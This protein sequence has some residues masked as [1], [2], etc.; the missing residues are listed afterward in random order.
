MTWGPKGDVSIITEP[1]I[2]QGLIFGQTSSAEKVD[3]L[4]D[5]LSHMYPMDETGDQT[6]LGE[7]DGGYDL[8]ARNSPTKV[9]GKISDAQQY[10]TGAV[11]HYIYNELGHPGDQNRSFSL[12]CW[13][14]TDTTPPTVSWYYFNQYDYDDDI[15]SLAIKHDFASGKFGI[16]MQK[17]STDPQY[18]FTLNLAIVQGTWYHVIVVYT[19]G[20]T[21]A[22]WVNNSTTNSAAA[23]YGRATNSHTCFGSRKLDGTG[24]GEVSVDAF[25]WW[26]NYTLTADDRAYMYNSGTGRE[27]L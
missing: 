8:T 16:V 11:N 9:A 7:Y 19:S 23:D 4:M 5:N 27:L 13:L 10:D 3:P 6:D 21:L 2:A 15:D 1:T 17:S 12:S 26:Q 25:H 24:S 22:A 18:A 20:S 14:R